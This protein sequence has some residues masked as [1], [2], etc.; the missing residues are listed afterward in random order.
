MKGKQINKVIQA[1]KRF[2]LYMMYIEQERIK[3]MIHSGWGK[4]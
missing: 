3:S 1:F 4:F 2:H